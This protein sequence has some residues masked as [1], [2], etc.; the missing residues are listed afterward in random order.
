[1][2]QLPVQNC[3]PPQK[4]L[5]PDEP[6][7]LGFKIEMDHIPNGSFRKDV[8]VQSL[9]LAPSY[10]AK[11]S[12]Y[13]YIRRLMDLP[14]LLHEHIELVFNR[15]AGKASIPLL[16]DLVEYLRSTWINSTTWPPKSLSVFQQ[17]VI[18]NNDAEGY[19]N[20][21][22]HR[23]RENLPFYLIIELL[24]RESRFVSVQARLLSNNKLIRYR[25][26]KYTATHAKYAQYWEGYS[27][28]E[29]TV[30]TKCRCSHKRPYYIN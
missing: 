22:N 5:R 10:L 16:C 1:M 11:D 20:R 8:Q 26:K 13:I 15:L 6:T 24:H 14:F 27:N 9:G 25:K 21:L 7:D 3:Q 18:T 17:G 29:R 2:D 28:V 12:L 19:H 4:K 23:G 30:I